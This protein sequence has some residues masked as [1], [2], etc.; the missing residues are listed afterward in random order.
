[1]SNR[2]NHTVVDFML[3]GQKKKLE[4]KTLQQKIDN[5]PNNREGRRVLAEI[6]RRLEKQTK[7]AK[8]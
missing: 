6:A 2:N 1:M 3:R 8:P 4:S 5:I 7:K